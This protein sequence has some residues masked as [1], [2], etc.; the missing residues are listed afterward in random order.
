MF[1]GTL[2]GQSTEGCGISSIGAG[3]TINSEQG[4]RIATLMMEA[5]GSSEMSVL[6]RSTRRHIPE[7]GTVHSHRRENLRS[8]NRVTNFLM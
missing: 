3:F 4:L 6:T 5:I 1:G 2:N 7:D 8:Y